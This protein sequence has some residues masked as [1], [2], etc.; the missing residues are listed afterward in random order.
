MTA[1]D[2]ETTE[3]SA[4]YSSVERINR[5]LYSKLSEA[6]VCTEPIATVDHS[7]T[8]NDDY[9]AIPAQ[10]TLKVP[11]YEKT[12]KPC[13]YEVAIPR[14]FKDNTEHNTI[15]ETLPGHEPII[16]MKIQ[17]TRKRKFMLGLRKRNF[18]NFKEMI[19]SNYVAI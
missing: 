5:D 7:K 11:H 9:E 14:T 15:N 10:K 19:S 1:D 3:N 18:E 6:M 13:D 4:Y 17:G 12:E 2:Y 16:Y 8:S